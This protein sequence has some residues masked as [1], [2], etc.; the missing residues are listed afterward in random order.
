MILVANRSSAHFHGVKL[1]ITSLL[2]IVLNGFL[3]A[4]NTSQLTPQDAQQKIEAWLDLKKSLAEERKD[5]KIRQA[6]IE[7]L[8]GVYLTELDLLEEGIAAAGELIEDA[9]AELE[10]LKLSTAQYRESRELL[11]RNVDKQSLRLLGIMKRFPGP[12]RNQISADRLA[13]EDSTTKL[14]VKVIAMVAV[15]KSTVKFNQVITYSEEVQVVDGVER[16]LQVLYFGLARG[17]Y[18]SGNTAGIAEVDSTGW[19][20]TRKDQHRNAIA[21]AIGV[22]QKTTRPELVKLPIQLTK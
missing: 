1:L 20:W 9:D 11:Q 12:L 13:L 18:I 8:L 4:Q 14:R 22:Y 5:F 2:F 19:N 3:A 7:Q 15:V 21:R 10:G 16:Q 17:Y 6:S